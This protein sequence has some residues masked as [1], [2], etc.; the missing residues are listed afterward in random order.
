MQAAFKLG[1]DAKQSGSSK[2]SN[3]RP[4]NCVLSR[5]RCPPTLPAL[6]TRLTR[7]SMRWSHAKPECGIKRILI[8]CWSMWPQSTTYPM[9]P[10]Q[11]SAV[12]DLQVAG[13]ARSAN[14]SD[15]AWFMLPKDS[16]V[17]DA[18]IR[19]T[20]SPMFGRVIMGLV[21]ANC[22]SMAIDNPACSKACQAG[23]STQ[24][25]RSA[26]RMLRT[27]AVTHVTHA[28]YDRRAGPTSAPG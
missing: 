21:L 28:M 10:Y 2:R 16:R 18:C 25:V 14:A 9:P 6:L 8:C 23:S 15:H 27:A 7:V 17:R 12:L 24:R 13:A 5:V 3:A 1:K 26:S 20:G 22:F 19:M 4:P 11:L